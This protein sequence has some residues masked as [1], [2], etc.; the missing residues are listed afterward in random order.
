MRPRLATKFLW[1]ILAIVALSIVSSL[2]ALYGTWRVATRL[3]EI[4]Q[5][6][7]PAARA[8]DIQAMIRERNEWLLAYLLDKNNSSAFKK[9]SELTPRFKAWLNA[10]RTMTY[11]S[12]DEQTLLAKLEK[13][14]TG[15]EAQQ[16]AIIREAGTASE[17]AKRQATGEIS[18]GLS[19]QADD[20][21]QQLIAANN[22]YVKG[23]MD[24]AEARVLKT[25]WT[26]AGFAILSLLLGGFL[27]WLFFYR[28]LFPL[29]GMVADARLFR[30]DGLAA[31]SGDDELRIMGNYLRNL[32]S[33][34][35]D[36]RSRLQQSH[37][38]LLAAEKLASV[39]KLAASVAHEIR[40]P[41]TAIK[42]WLFSIQDGAS[43]E[44]LDR[45]L[46]IVSDEIK[47]L[48]SIVRSFL[49]FSRPPAL[50]RRPE[51][52]GKLIDETL[53]LLAPHLKEGQICLE[54][55]SSKNRPRVMA[56]RAQ[57]KQ[58][59]LNLINNAVDAMPEGGAI[60]VT[61]TEEVAADGRTMV[62][63]RIRDSGGGIA[64]D[65]QSR[66]FE[67]FF[68][69]KESGTGLGLCIAAQVMAAH[70][71]ALVLESSAADGTTFAV[72]I[73]IAEEPINGQ[74]SG[75]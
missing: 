9:L 28:V 1:T 53:E 73:P 72:W 51:C 44:T 74:D 69:T 59:L 58:V 32:M 27:L 39:G 21:C 37:D 36:T 19:K 5:E 2:V 54:R 16:T 66:I 57:L 29:R 75:G 70:G 33:D 20:L 41:L 31:K 47:R 34:V 55:Q 49:E 65:V 25:T 45:K 23:L 62:V 14:W 3:E 68:T 43:R 42:M 15:L 38:R 24:R 18:G 61:D 40:N 67:P 11:V 13:A 56:D 48:E 50:H 63:V 64:P 7:L 10:V 12:P 6:S 35:S 30:G 22:V 52:V 60:S 71:G 46:Q 17:D 4:A 26:V 8:E